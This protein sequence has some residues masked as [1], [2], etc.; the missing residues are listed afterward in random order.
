MERKKLSIAVI[1]IV[2]LILL[3]SAFISVLPYINIGKLD[4]RQAFSQEG[5]VFTLH[6]PTDNV[7]IFP[8]TEAKVYVDGTYFGELAIKETEI[9]PGET[10]IA[11]STFIGNPE[12]NT[13]LLNPSKV[14]YDGISTIYYLGIPSKIPFKIEKQVAENE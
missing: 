3:I 5:I 4:F 7:I 6:N 11:N 1:A 8:E 9:K 2:I 14:V 12:L 13:T 10:K